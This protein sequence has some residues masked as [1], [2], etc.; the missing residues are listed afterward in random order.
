[1]GAVTVVLLVLGIAVALV[2]ERGPWLMPPSG[3]V[4]ETTAPEMAPGMEMPA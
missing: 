3:M 1:M 2:P 4:D